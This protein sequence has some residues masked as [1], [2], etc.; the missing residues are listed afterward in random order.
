VLYLSFPSLKDPT[1][2][3]Q[4]MQIIIPIRYDKFAAWRQM[5]WKRRGS[6]Y[7]H[8]KTQIA[9]RMLG[10]VEAR[11][12]GLR[13]LVAYQEV[14]TPLTVEAFTGNP[15]GAVYGL[16]FTPHRL[17]AR[18]G[19]ANTPVKGLLLT[20]ADGCTLGIEGALAG[21]F[22]AVAATMG[23]AGLPTLMRLAAKEARTRREPAQLPRESLVKEH[24]AI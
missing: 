23:P 5:P 11:Y 1:A 14:S 4:T 17:E 20:G 19:A 13:A 8:L 2:T 9:D 6:D 22:F 10:A 12:P 16:P 18:I 15:L 21:G 24:P 7:E 3:V